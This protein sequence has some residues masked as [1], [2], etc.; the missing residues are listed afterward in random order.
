VERAR[1]IGIR[2]AADEA[3]LL[4][5]SHEPSHA[6]RREH[7]GLRKVSHSQATTGRVV[8]RNQ[9]VEFAHMPG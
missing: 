8:E 9:H 6:A 7:R 2:V 1:I 5:S 3:A 4:E